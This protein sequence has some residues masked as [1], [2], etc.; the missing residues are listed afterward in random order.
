MKN[1]DLTVLANALMSAPACEKNALM[2]APAPACEKIAE[3]VDELGAI[4]A[5][6]ADLICR[7][8]H[9]RA[10]LED[11]GL[12][13]IDGKQYTATFSQVPARVLIDSEK[14]AKRFT[15]SPQLIR[16]YTKTG[17]PSTRLNVTARKINH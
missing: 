10:E 7:S 15:P 9:I 13:T 1:Q 8:D 2:S 11:A 12:K 5:E 16:A 14:I 3:K 6:I 4:R 17:K